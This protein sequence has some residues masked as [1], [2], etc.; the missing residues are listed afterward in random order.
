MRSQRVM[1]SSRTASCHQRS[2]R[3][4]AQPEQL[5]QEIAFSFSVARAARESCST[6]ACVLPRCDVAHVWLPALG[7]RQAV[8]TVCAAD[9][10]GVA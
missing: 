10:S 1:V 6:P 2:G 7:V 8:E 4:G 5:P 3:Q 9:R